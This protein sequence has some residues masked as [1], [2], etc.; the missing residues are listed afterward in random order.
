MV[1][2]LRRRLVSVFSHFSLIEVWEFHSRKNHSYINTLYLL[3]LLEGK[4][5]C[6]EHSHTSHSTY[7]ECNTQLFRLFDVPESLTG[8]SFL[9]KSALYTKHYMMVETLKDGN[10][11]NEQASL[12]RKRKHVLI[13]C[14]L[15]V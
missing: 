8:N 12:L 10:I 4:P 11:V 3:T 2:K 15:V 9:R 1:V 13:I 6:D 14:F 5:S 7:A